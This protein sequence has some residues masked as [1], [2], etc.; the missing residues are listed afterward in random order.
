MV[1]MGIAP[2]NKVLHININNGNNNN[3]T[4]KQ[5]RFNVYLSSK[6]LRFILMG[7]AG[8]G[9]VAKPTGTKTGAAQG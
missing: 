2:I 8:T 5:R 7:W 6:P 1:T 3:S 9:V 4:E